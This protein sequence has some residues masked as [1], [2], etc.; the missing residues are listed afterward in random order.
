MFRKI[1][2]FD[3]GYF[4]AVTCFFLLWYNL[5]LPKVSSSVRTI[6][7]LLLDIIG[8]LLYC[9]VY[10]LLIRNDIR[11]FWGLLVV[12]FIYTVAQVL[13]FL[14]FIVRSGFSGIDENISFFLFFY[15]S[16]IVTVSVAFTCSYFLTRFLITLNSNG[17]RA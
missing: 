9:I 11:Y 8:P 4:I 1:I 13:S 10:K 2:V 14:V 16:S 17:D 12:L 5:E 3:V 15:R 7:Y 6:A